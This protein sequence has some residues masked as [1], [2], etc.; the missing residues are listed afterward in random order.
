ML[1]IIIPALNEEKYLPKLLDSIKNQVF[2]NY[3]IIVADNNSVDKTV[4]IAKNYGCRISKG[5]MPGVARN[6]GAKI[7]RGDLLLF[8]DADVILPDK[9]LDKL[10]K[11]FLR[12]D[13]GVASCFI[14]PQDKNNFLIFF[15]N[16]FYNIPGLF[17]QKF[18]CPFAM[19]FI[20]VKKDIHKKINGFNEEVIFNEDIDYAKRALK[21]EKFGLLSSSKILVSTRRFKK[22]GWI[23][24]F[25]KYMYAFLYTSFIG[26][27]KSNIF[28]YKFGSYE[29]GDS[30]HK[31]TKK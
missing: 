11:E 3:E 10:I 27:I 19:N 9:S 21:I 31:E 15:Y 1:S 4:E 14:S 8:L 23:K 29:N 2:N 6:E 18:K 24:T 7:A 5:G 30:Q 17:L 28:E 22:D 26:P 16:I 25:L 13:L 20:L 12:R